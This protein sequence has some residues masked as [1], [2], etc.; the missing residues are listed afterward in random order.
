MDAHAIIFHGGMLEATEVTSAAF[1]GE[2]LRQLLMLMLMR[3][4]R[5]V[6]LSWFAAAIANTTIGVTIIDFIAPA[7]VADADADEAIKMCVCVSVL[8]CGCHCQHHQCSDNN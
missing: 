6:C 5:C 4:L 1:K 8:V 7:A 2:R 3:S